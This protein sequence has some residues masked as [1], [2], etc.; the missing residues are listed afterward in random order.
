MLFCL[1]SL[2]FQASRAFLSIAL[3]QKRI[4]VTGYFLHRPYLFIIFILQQS[5]R[6]QTCKKW[7]WSFRKHRQQNVT[8]CDEIDCWA[9]QHWTPQAHKSADLIK[10]SSNVK[11]HLYHLKNH[12]FVF[13]LSWGIH[14]ERQPSMHDII[15]ESKERR[16]DK[17][18]IKLKNSTLF[19]WEGRQS[20]SNLPMINRRR[21]SGTILEIE[22]RH[23]PNLSDMGLAHRILPYTAHC[24]DGEP[25]ARERGRVGKMQL[26]IK[27]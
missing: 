7:W 8:R 16:K 14:W 10:T 21:C 2:P 11:R 13:M 4:G 12:F 22:N 9:I 6:Y 15:I 5:Y 19:Q 18:F 24:G 1:P 3:W 17:C 26:Q 27:L 20:L 23:V 25:R